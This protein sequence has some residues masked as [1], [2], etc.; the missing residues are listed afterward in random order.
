VSAQ[1]ATVRGPVGSDELGRALLHEHILIAGPEGVVNH[2]RLW[3]E[4]WWD[5]DAR[6]ADAVVKLR[7]L[8]AAGYRTL[9]DPTAFGMGR[10]VH[11]IARIN[12][13]VDLHIVVCTGIYAFLEVPCPLKY[14]SAENLA[15]IFERELREG[16]DGTGI[17]AGFLKCCLERDGFIGD[18]PLIF[19]AIGLAATATGAPVMVH[20]NGAAQTGRQALAELTARG[21]APQRIVIAHAGDSTDLDYHRELADA[22]AMLGFDRFNTGFSTDEARVASIAVLAA[23]GYAD[24]IHLS[25]DAAAFMDFMEHNPPMA[26][27]QG[28]LDYLHLEHRVLPQLREA[29]V[30]EPQIEEM[31]VTNARRFL[32]GDA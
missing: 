14:R 1:V 17:R 25:H 13:E 20:T 16:I 28:T 11:R 26:G 5:E 18:L 31:L 3:G 32:A 15:S 19:D 22:G 7:R 24:R 23:E 10:D 9:V 29:G 12:R 30:S 4:P 21:V 8:H 2:N 6:V 27:R